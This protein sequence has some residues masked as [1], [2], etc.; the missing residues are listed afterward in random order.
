M[1]QDDPG[2]PSGAPELSGPQR[3]YLRSLGHHLE[4]VVQIGKSGVTDGV[5]AAVVDA[6]EQHELI[7]IRIGTEC[8][9]PRQAVADDLARTVGVAIAQ[10][11]GRV[12]LAYRA[13]P[14]E[15]TI[16]LPR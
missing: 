1:E 8:P 7:K 6:I 2:Q 16:R 15:P 4:P 13:R 3:R 9:E 12:V 14:Q 11:I 10:V 5:R